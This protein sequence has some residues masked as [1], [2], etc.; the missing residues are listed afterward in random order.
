[1][2]GD[3]GKFTRLMPKDCE[4]IDVVTIAGNNHGAVVRPGLVPW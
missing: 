4:V 1:M 3:L 2:D